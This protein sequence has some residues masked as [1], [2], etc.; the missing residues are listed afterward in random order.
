M[1]ISIKTAGGI[2]IGGIVGF[3]LINKALNFT[4]QSIAEITEASKWRAYYK[5]GHEGNMVP[6]GY[7][8][9][10]VPNLENCEYVHPDT[11]DE[12]EKEERKK[13]K[14]QT[15][16]P[17]DTAPIAESLERIAKAFM[18]SKGIDLDKPVAQ[19][20]CRYSEP[21]SEDSEE[22]EDIPVSVTGVDEVFEGEVVEVPGPEAAGEEETTEE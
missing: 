22:A 1:G 15:K 19:S 20:Y 14:E 6:P 17:I 18:K 11:V 13:A 9:M 16:S 8:R 10:P 21:V 3:Y 7:S 2:A 12:R 5:H 4:R